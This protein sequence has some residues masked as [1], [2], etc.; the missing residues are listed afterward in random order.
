MKK[1]V[2]VDFGMRCMKCNRKLPDSWVDSQVEK[3]SICKSCST[4][5][6]LW[7]SDLIILS[8]PSGRSEAV[9][10]NHEREKNWIVLA[11]TNVQ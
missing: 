9:L 5:K 8:L 6:H 1:K 2:K 11:G 3:T 10:E 7:G 4:P